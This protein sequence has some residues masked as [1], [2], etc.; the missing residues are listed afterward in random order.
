MRRTA[1]AQECIG[2]KRDLVKKVGGKV[3]G[4]RKKFEEC[5]KGRARVMEVKV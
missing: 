5:V 1:Q 3:E 4:A 2:N